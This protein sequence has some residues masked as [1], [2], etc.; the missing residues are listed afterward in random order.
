MPEKSGLTFQ[1]MKM[2]LDDMKR[3]RS[4]WEALWRDVSTYILPRRLKKD[5]RTSGENLRAG[6]YDSTAERA[7]NRLG[8]VIQSMLTNPETKWFG[9]KLNNPNLMK[10]E[11]VLRWLE[12][13]R[14]RVIEI[15]NDSNFSQAADE[16][17]LDMGGIGTGIMLIE[18]GKS[19]ILNFQTLPIYECYLAENDEGIID[20][21]Y[22]EYEMTVAQ[23]VQQF[24]WD[25]L[26]KR[27]Q[28]KFNKRKYD[29]KVK[30]VHAIEPRKEFIKNPRSA[31]EFPWASVYFS[32]EDKQVMHEGGYK[33]F[34]AVCP[35]WRKASG[36]VYG[37]G[38]GI[39]CISDIK[40]LNEMVYTNL[41]ACHR[42]VDP[43]LDH[44]E[45]AYET[46]LDL[47]PGAINI[48][49]KNANKAEA[50]YLVNGLPVSLELQQM[51]QSNINDS[52]FYQQ[53]SL[54][55]NDRMTATE[56]IQ[57]TEENMR[58]LGPTFGRF[59]S[60]FLEPLI[61]RVLSILSDADMLPEAP[62]IIA[63][64]GGYRIEYESPL[65][66]A[67]KSSELQAI[68]RAIMVAAPALQMK[69]DAIL[70]LKIDDLLR[71]IFILNGVPRDR[72]RTEK[73]VAAM[74]EEIAR[75][76]AAAEAMAQ[77]EVAA[78]TAKVASEADPRA[79]LLGTVFPQR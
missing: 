76:Q 19:K 71:D 39:E 20:T 75:R 69:P 53:L 26:P 72:L 22:R 48:R 23:C 60:E 7:N 50:L 25:E 9:V 77:A 32:V 16:L 55:D 73:E 47:S 3:A 68:E 43:P 46:P 35:R 45:D 34:P 37:R 79:G 29:D 10:Q 54:I 12:E 5:E 59:Q 56:V 8:S 18:S 42:A 38:P 6:M 11:I 21:L 41:M 2:R 33:S 30:I 66:R 44:E 27:V 1:D 24:E 63:N 78:K 31:K 57:R 52:F 70:V 13:L 62:A 36:E 74:R 4:N 65:A 40:T 61:R 14:D 28:E 64:S 67:Q 15:M 58:I 51:Y 17:Y 49:S